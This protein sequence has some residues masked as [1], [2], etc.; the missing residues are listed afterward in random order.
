MARRRSRAPGVLV[1]SGA[2]LCRWSAPRHRHRRRRRRVGALA[3]I[4][5]RQL[6]R[7]GSDER[8]VG[9]DRHRRRPIGHADAP[10]VDRRGE[11]RSRHRGNGRR[12]G[13]SERH[14][15][16]RRSVRPPRNPQCGRPGGLPR[17]AAVPARRGPTA[18]G[19]PGCGSGRPARG[20][21]AV[22]RTGDRVAVVRVF[23]RAGGSG[24]RSGYAQ[25]RISACGRGAARRRDAAGRGRAGRAGSA[26]GW[27]ATR[28]RRAG[29]GF[30]AAGTGPAAAGTGPAAACPDRAGPDRTCPDRP[31]SA[32]TGAR[33]RACAGRR[34]D[35]AGRAVAAA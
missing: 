21:R 19:G 3:G 2:S 7:H 8:Q 35:S 9:D 28:R 15:G 13:R 24:C 32:R 11:R 29:R 27:G 16:A 34:C 31:C 30:A 10:R 33:S 20:C 26:G 25:G 5:R 12:D 6:R 22:R 17:P 23:A 14:A 4:G 1:R 18:C